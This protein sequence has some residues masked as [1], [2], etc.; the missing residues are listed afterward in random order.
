MKKVFLTLFTALLVITADAQGLKKFYDET[1]NPVE[2]IDL[3]VVK[4]KSEGK[5][6]IWLDDDG[7]VIHIQDSSFLEEGA[8]LQSGESIALL[9]E[10]DTKSC[11][12]MTLRIIHQSS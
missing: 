11:E 8:G 3:A 12:A 6:V 7:E 2:Q 5:F 4:A 9:Q 1:I 10:L